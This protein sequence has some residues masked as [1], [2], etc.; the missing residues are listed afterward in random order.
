MQPICEQQIK[1]V[2]LPQFRLRESDSEVSVG[3]TTLLHCFLSA[4]SSQL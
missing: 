4:L 2:N 1:Q 3:Y